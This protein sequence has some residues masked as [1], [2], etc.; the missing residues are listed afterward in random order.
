M[1][2]PRSTKLVFLRRSKTAL[3]LREYCVRRG[4]VSGLVQQ[5]SRCG[6]LTLIAVSREVVVDI[7]ANSLPPLRM[8]DSGSFLSFIPRHSIICTQCHSS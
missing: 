7:G 1:S 5:V 2:A 8:N 3:S 6:W 4:E